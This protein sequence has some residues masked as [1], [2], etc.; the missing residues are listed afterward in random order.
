MSPRLSKR[1]LTLA[2]VI[3]LL[4]IAFTFFT[5]KFQV[6]WSELWQPSNIIAEQTEPSISET[7]EDFLNLKVLT[8]NT[9]GIPQP[10]TTDL[11]S[12]IEETIKAVKDYDIVA[13]Q[14]TFSKQ[15]E[16]LALESEFTNYIR[17]DNRSL[18]HLGSGLMLLSRYPI[19]EYDFTSFTKCTSYDCL[20]NKGVLFARIQLP[21]QE[22]IDVYTTHYQAGHQ[23]V[24][25]AGDIRIQDN[26]DLLNF[27]NSKQQ[28]N[29]T[30]FLGDFNFVPDSEEYVDFVGKLGVI[31]LCRLENAN[32]ICPTYSTGMNPYVED[33]NTYYGAE[34]EWENQLDHIFVLRKEDSSLEE[35]TAQV[36]FNT[37]MDGIFLSDHF[38]LLATFSISSK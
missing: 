24:S 22:K 31:D 37:A 30:V 5:L 7:Q 34:T 15:A 9:W 11:T 6:D 4:L 14:E 8:L 35:Q 23:S 27:F 18:F 26:S 38:G 3:F 17:M 16:R 21:N 19:L 12:R 13:F 20:A 36:V 28:G 1:S 2:L 32:N 33:A 25:E 10:V 29:F